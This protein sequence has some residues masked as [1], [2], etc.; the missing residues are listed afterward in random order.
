VTSMWALGSAVQRALYPRGGGF[1]A[2]EGGE[3]FVVEPRP[4]DCCVLP[5]RHVPEAAANLIA[6]LA[7]LPDRG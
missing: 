5:E 7:D 3:R 4:V 1:V 6:T 2:E